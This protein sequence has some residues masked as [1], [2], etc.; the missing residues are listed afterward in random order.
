LQAYLGEP[1]CICVPPF[2]HVLIVGGGGVPPTKYLGGSA[3][4]RVPP[5]LHYSIDRDPS[6]LRVQ[7]LENSWRC[8]LATII[9]YYIACCEAVRSAILATAWL[10]VLKL[11]MHSIQW[12]ASV[13]Q[14]EYDTRGCEFD[15]YMI[16]S[17]ALAHHVWGTCVILYDGEVLLFLF[18]LLFI[19]LFI[20]SYFHVCRHI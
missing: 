3:V 12:S 10:L 20:L 7:Y 11:H 15:Q 13:T 2:P 18:K 4:P 1:Y 6:V 5:P 9:N 16:R 17:S 8:Y 14:Y 19:Y